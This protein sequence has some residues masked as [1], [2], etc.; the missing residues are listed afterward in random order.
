MEGTGS[1]SGAIREGKMVQMEEKKRGKGRKI[2]K[3]IGESIAGNL[4][5]ASDTHFQRG[6]VKYPCCP[7]NSHFGESQKVSEKFLLEYYF[8]PQTMQPLAGRYAKRGGETFTVKACAVR[9]ASIAFLF[10]S[11]L[12]NIFRAGVSYK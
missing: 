12:A 7:T 8:R 4:N 1:E 3:N 5:L 9:T 6:C 2:M 11:N 10:P